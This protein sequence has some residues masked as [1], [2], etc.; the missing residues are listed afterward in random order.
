MTKIDISLS[1][2]NQLSTNFCY[3]FNFIF[4]LSIRHLPLNRKYG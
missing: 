1:D 4:S 2:M 3:D